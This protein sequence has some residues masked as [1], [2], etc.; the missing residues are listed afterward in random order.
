LRAPAGAAILTA[1][2]E[3]GRGRREE[4]MK[5]ELIVGAKMPDLELTDHRHQRVSLSSVA[6]GFPLILT[7]YRGYW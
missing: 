5:P 1:P 7:F 3:G 6:Q 4:P 2:V